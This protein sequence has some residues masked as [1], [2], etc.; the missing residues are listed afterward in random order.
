MKHYYLICAIYIVVI[1]IVIS[2]IY[3]NKGEEIRM[4][5]GGGIVINY[6]KPISSLNGRFSKILFNVTK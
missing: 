5:C 1:F 2:L 3:W 4:R 6:T